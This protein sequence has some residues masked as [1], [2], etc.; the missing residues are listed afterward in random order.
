MAIDLKVEKAVEWAE[1][2]A[3]DDTHGYDQVKRWGPDYDC[4]S[5]VISAFEQAG[6]K[7][8]SAGATYTGNMLS[9]FI[10]CGFEKVTDGSLMRGD[11]LLHPKYHTALMTSSSELVHASIDERGKTTGGK[12]GDQ[13]GKEICKRSY[14]RYSKGWTYVLRY[15][16]NNA[17]DQTEKEVK[18]VTIELTELSKGSKGSEVKSLQ[19]LLNGKG[20]SLSIDGDFGTKTNIAVRDYQKAHS[21][22]VD[23]IVGKNTWTALLTT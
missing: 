13:T 19:R 12:T 14:Y 10:K 15:K 3:A 11:V 8:K 22:T 16:G 6:I 9:N 2:I 4:S 23:G 7:V 1:A 17:T 5:L 20:Y 18:K 21:L